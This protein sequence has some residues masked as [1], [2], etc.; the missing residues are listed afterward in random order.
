MGKDATVEIS[1]EVASPPAIVPSGTPARDSR[2][3]QNKEQN[4]SLVSWIPDI[5][6]SAMTVPVVYAPIMH[7]RP[8]CKRKRRLNKESLRIDYCP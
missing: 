6:E 7:E 5:S 8:S 4:T 1:H 2:K 3:E